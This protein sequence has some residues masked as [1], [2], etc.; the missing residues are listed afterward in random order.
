MAGRLRGRKEPAKE[1]SSK[2]LTLRQGGGPGNQFQ[3]W[4]F[5]ASDLYN[6]KSHNPSFSQ[7]PIAL[8]ALIESI[9]ITHQPTWDDCQQL[10]Q[11]LLTTEERQKVYLEARKNVPGDNGRPT[12][13]PNV[14]DATFPL[15][16]LTGISIRL[17]VGPT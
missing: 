1:G 9:L 6:W 14:I 3:Y 10:L 13:L 16:R 4:P 7:D 12:Q 8:T 17:K 5:S 15:T 11:T 2:L